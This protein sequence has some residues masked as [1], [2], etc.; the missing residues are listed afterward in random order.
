MAKLTEYEL[1]RQ[2]NIERNRK[3]LE[4]FNLDAIKNTVLVTKPKPPPKDTKKR[5]A[6]SNGSDAAKENNSNGVSEPRPRKAA[7][8]VETRPDGNEVRSLRRSTRN[9]GKKVDYNEIEQ[10]RSARSY[11]VSSAARL[12]MQGEPRENMKRTQ[13]P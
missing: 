9:A 10:D 6:Q 7:R 8:I 13:D 3:I 2:R 1:E 5:K 12:E 4:S 11:R